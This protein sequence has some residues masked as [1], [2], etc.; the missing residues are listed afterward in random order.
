MN[1]T[2]ITSP[3]TNHSHSNSQSTI[4]PDLSS[5]ENRA[6][7]RRRSSLDQQIIERWKFLVEQCKTPEQLPWT[8]QKR[9]IRR[10]FR[11]HHKDL[12]R[13]S[14]QINISMHEQLEYINDEQ[15]H[16]FHNKQ[17]NTHQMIESNM[18]DYHVIQMD[19]V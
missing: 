15:Y 8:I 16:L 1:E 7:V 18:Q 4:L 2:L 11:R 9:M 3:T 17:M 10:H 12:L 19:K 5:I 6:R 14:E 13:E